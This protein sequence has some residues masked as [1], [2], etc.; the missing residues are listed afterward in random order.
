MAAE[1]PEQG[2]QPGL[3]APAA[4]GVS[5]PVPLPPAVHSAHG[6]GFPIHLPFVE[7]LKRHNVGRVGLGSRDSVAALTA[8]RRALEIAPEEPT[9]RW[10]LGSLQLLQGQAADSLATFSKVKLDVLRLSG[11]ASAEHTLGHP[12]KSQ[13]VLAQLVLI[14]TQVSA[15]EVAT[16]HAWRGEKDIAFEWLERA[17]REHCNGLPYIKT[18]PYFDGVRQ[19]QDPRYLELLR[20]MNLPE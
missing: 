7:K 13:Q 9:V 15:Y 16:V 20:K 12:E 5:A 11:I 18:D 1:P 17:Y 6:H 8:L 3:S 4:D 19:D 10:F 2:T 14:P